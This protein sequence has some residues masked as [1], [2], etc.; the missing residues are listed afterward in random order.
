VNSRVLAN[1]IIGLD[2][3]TTFNHRSAGLSFPQ[4]RLRF[5]ALRKES[6][7]IVIGGNS[8]R[9]EP[10]STTP[11]PLI[12]LSHTD[13]LPKE[14]I[15]NTR[16]TLWNKNIVDAV[17]SAK[18]MYE[19]ILIEAGPALLGPALEARLVDELHIC[20]SHTSGG[21]SQISLKDFTAGYSQI[22]REEVEGGAFITYIPA[23]TE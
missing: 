23:P 5:H 15:A 22:K 19:N 8:A 2:G 17:N 7:V 11:V 3:S 16:A 12:V 6:D 13:Q 1:L 18:E 10:Y 9:N 21:E 20:I 14:L 4:D